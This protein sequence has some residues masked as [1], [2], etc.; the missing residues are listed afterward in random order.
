MPD[1][2][3]GPTRFERLLEA[4]A[5]PVGERMLRPI[6]R[7]VGWYATARGEGGSGAVAWARVAPLEVVVQEADG[8]QHRLAVADPTDMIMRRM[9]GA[10]AALA[11]IC[12]AIMAIAAAVRALRK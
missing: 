4:E 6:A 12:G 8:H 2:K 10:M 3:A 11:L 7:A 1:H 5:I 9:Y